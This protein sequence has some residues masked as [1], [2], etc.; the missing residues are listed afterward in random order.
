MDIGKWLVEVSLFMN[1]P[2]TKVLE[3]GVSTVAPP[4]DWLPSLYVISSI[5]L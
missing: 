2:D 3:V 4:Q 1:F 5:F